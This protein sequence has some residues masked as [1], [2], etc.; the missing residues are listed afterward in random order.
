M[1][2]VLLLLVYNNMTNKSLSFPYKLIDFFTNI[3]DVG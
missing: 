2:E 1:F 3:L